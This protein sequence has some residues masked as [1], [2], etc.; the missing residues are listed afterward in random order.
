VRYVLVKREG[1]AS[2]NL[3]DLASPEVDMDD[4]VRRR[5]GARFAPHGRR[6]KRLE[7]V[8]LPQSDVPPRHFKTLLDCGAAAQDR[9]FLPLGAIPT[10]DRL[11]DERAFSRRLW[12]VSKEASDRYGGMRL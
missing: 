5:S 8:E 1:V 11:A 4:L 3:D 2:G 9:D 10:N 7:A 12:G 6:V